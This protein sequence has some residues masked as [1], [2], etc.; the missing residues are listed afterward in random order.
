MID[1]QLYS[2]EGP[3][4]VLTFENSSTFLIIKLS[5]VLVQDMSVRLE[6]LTI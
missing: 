1:G 6:L 3:M 4:I 2:R 5:P